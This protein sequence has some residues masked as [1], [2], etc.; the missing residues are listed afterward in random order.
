[1]GQYQSEKHCGR[2]F[3]SQN[4]KKD[5]YSYEKIHDK[6][7]FALIAYNNISK[8]FEHWDNIDVTKNTIKIL[9]NPELHKSVVILVKILT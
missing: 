7:M 8:N 4:D 6:N 3:V 5:N 2:D 9:I 1:M